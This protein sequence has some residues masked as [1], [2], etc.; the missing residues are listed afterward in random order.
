MRHQ[1]FTR[2][3]R[4]SL[5]QGPALPQTLCVF[6]HNVISC[7][8]LHSSTKHVIQK[9]SRN[10]EKTTAE[11]KGQNPKALRRNKSQTNLIRY[12]SRYSCNAVC[13]VIVSTCSRLRGRAGRLAEALATVK[14]LSVTVT[15]CRCRAP[16]CFRAQVPHQQITHNTPRG[17]P[18]LTESF[19]LWFVLFVKFSV[20]SGKRDRSHR[21]FLVRLKDLR[22]CV[23]RV[24]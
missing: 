18:R 19:L 2:I 14:P 10:L 13:S 6:P 12:Q 9:K 1:S 11:K 16:G 17:F 3:H 4:L 15:L 23:K 5:F 21:V 22:F 8:S 7:N 24:L 20:N